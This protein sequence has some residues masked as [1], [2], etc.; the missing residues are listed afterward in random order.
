VCGA[1][2]TRSLG[3]IEAFPTSDEL[4]AAINTIE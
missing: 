1:L 4:A 2:S 3:G